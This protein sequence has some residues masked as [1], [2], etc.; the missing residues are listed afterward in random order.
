MNDD[1]CSKPSKHLRQLLSEVVSKDITSS[2]SIGVLFSGGLDSSVITAILSTVHSAS[3]QLFVAGIESAKD[4]ELAR[5]AAKA[6]NLPLTLCLFT[7]DDVKQSLPKIVSRLGCTDVLH[8][9]LAIPHYFAAKYAHQFG[10]TTFFSGQGADELFGGYAKHEK[11][12]LESGEQMTLT[13]M[14][15]DLHTLL[16]ETLPLMSAIV[17]HSQI[18]LVAPFCDQALIDFASSLPFSCKLSQDSDKVIRKLILRLLAE[19]LNLPPQ[20]AYAPKRALQ[21]GSGAHRILTDLAAEYWI[22]QDPDLTQRQSR[23]HVRV[24]QYLARL[25]EQ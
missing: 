10:I 17:T 11:S 15:S 8:V 24:E 16:E 14:E 3:I 4:I 13:E 18:Q 12:F 21:Y 5:A 19:N 6:L 23:T 2:E 7:A 22:E 25:V 20:V 9:E 1:P